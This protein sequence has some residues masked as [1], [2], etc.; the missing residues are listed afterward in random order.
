M[1][2]KISEENTLRRYEPIESS[3]SW[4]NSDNSIYVQTT[5]KL[6]SKNRLNLPKLVACILQFSSK[7]AKELADTIQKRNVFAR[8]SGENSFYVLRT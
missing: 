7:E 1:E 2:R 5:S 3:R 8:N 6:V 4:L